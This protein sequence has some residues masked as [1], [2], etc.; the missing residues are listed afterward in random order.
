MKQLLLGFVLGIVV[1]ISIGATLYHPYKGVRIDVK[2]D[3]N[4]SNFRTVMENQ[5]AIFQLIEAK[6][7]KG[8][9]HDA[10]TK[11]RRQ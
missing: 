4:Y 10:E 9:D 1:C 2:Y 7:G 5:D 6:C 11:H 3:A 8:N